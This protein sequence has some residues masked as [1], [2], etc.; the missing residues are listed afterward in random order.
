[1]TNG[2][3]T[4]AEFAREFGMTTSAAG[5]RLVTLYVRGKAER[6]KRQDIGGKLEYLWRLT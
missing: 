6:V 4:T 3:Q 5:H 1:M 2:W